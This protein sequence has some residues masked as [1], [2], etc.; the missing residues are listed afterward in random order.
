MA[1]KKVRSIRL[2]SGDWQAASKCGFKAFECERITES[3][4]SCFNE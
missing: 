1:L 4:L 3:V 2:V